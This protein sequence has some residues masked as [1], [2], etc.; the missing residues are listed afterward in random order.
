[1]YW[2]K[3]LR[4][5]HYIPSPHQQY[6][7]KLKVNTVLPIQIS[8]NVLLTHPATWTYSLLLY[9]DATQSL[10]SHYIHVKVPVIALPRV[11][12]HPGRLYTFSR[13]LRT[14]DQILLGFYDDMILDAQHLGQQLLLC[15]RNK[16]DFDFVRKSC[17]AGRLTFSKISFCPKTIK[18]S[19]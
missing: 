17:H 15:C 10:S 4:C 1:M 6:T 18:L 3:G 7:I 11:V 9:N 8:D 19:K 16:L 2:E 5:S 14:S 12:V 13:L